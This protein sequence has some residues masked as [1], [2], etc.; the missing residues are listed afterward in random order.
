MDGLN[1]KSHPSLPQLNT[2]EGFVDI[3]LRTM[4]SDLKALKQSGG[5]VNFYKFA[6]SLHIAKIKEEKAVAQKEKV[7]EIPVQETKTVEESQLKPSSKSK[8]LKI[9][10]TIIII[11]FS[12]SVGY[13]ILPQLLPTK[14]SQKIEPKI[15]TP[16]P[17][18]TETTTPQQSTSSEETT[19]APN[20]T[21]STTE[22]I[23][24]EKI[25]KIKPDSNIE[26]TIDL[27]MPNFLKYY[28]FLILDS[29]SQNTPN[30]NA[31]QTKTTVSTPK[32]FSLLIKNKNGS[33]VSWNE[34]LK[35]L[36]INFYQD[37][38]WDN[39]SK[40]FIGFI[41]QNEKGVYPGYI[42]EIKSNSLLSLQLELKKTIENN[43]NALKN[44][45]ISEVDFSNSEFKNV[46]LGRESI[47]AIE[48]K[49]TKNVFVYGI[50]FNK[51]LVISTSLDGVKQLIQKM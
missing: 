25:F 6:E 5:I 30:T 22:T 11:V 9:I 1:D 14:K 50:I 24:L 49:D 16:L 3:T 51:Y 18:A 15:T 17:Q 46:P 42:L 21:T 36:N 44:F 39:F 27:E 45:F 8:T 28:K 37:N 10:L 48:S 23:S 7:P 32:I 33:L 38:I 34:F 43:K 13:F 19:T 20:I 4:D 2:E 41:Y 29:L 35:A 31:T 47:R 12:F 40:E 26:L